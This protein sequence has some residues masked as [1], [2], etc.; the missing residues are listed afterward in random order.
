MGFFSGAAATSFEADVGKLAPTLA[1]FAEGCELRNDAGDAA[2]GTALRAC[3]V[4]LDCAEV[5]VSAAGFVCAGAFVCGTT[6]PCGCEG[7]LVTGSEA[8]EACTFDS[9]P[10]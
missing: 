10:V 7:E 8:T 5:L 1:G 4:E 3:E 6:F 9:A 2:A